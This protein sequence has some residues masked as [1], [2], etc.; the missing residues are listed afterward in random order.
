MV[1]WAAQVPHSR[2]VRRAP[3]AVGQG[4][5]WQAAGRQ[6]GVCSALP[7]QPPDVRQGDEAGRMLG[8][9]G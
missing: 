5:Q 2:W 4:A 7:A 1:R 3:R 6:A 8:S 9:G